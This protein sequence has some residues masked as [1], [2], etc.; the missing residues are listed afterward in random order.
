MSRFTVEPTPL[1][2]LVGVQRQPLPD[3]RG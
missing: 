3:S 1:A 2:G